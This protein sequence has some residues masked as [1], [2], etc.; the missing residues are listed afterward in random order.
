MQRKWLV[1]TLMALGLV[2]MVSFAAL[3]QLPAGIPREETFIGS[4]LTGR[5]GTPSN[6]N[7]WSGWRW[8]D[9]GIQQLLLEPLWTV[10]YATGEIISGL[11]A[12]LPIYNEDSTQ[13]TINLRQGVYWSDDVPLTAD[14][15]VFTI[16]LHARIPGLIYHGP[17]AEFMKKVYK[18]D[19]YTV[20]VELKKPNAHFHSYFVDRW[21]CLYI[22]PKHIFEKVGD[23]MTFE[24][25]PPVSCGPYILYDY[26]P[27]GFWTLWERRED[28]DRTPTGMLYGKPQP[29]YVL[30]RAF[31]SPETE[32]LAILRH[33]LDATHTTMEAMRAALS[34]GQTV[35][36]YY[37]EWPWAEVNHPCITGIM[38]NNM[39]APY[40]NKEVRW[41]L[42]L[43]INIVDYMSIA[44]DLIGAVSPIH[45]PVLSTYI[46]PFF[47]P[48]EEWLKE[49][50]LDLGN[51]EK[52]KPYDPEAPFKLAE[53]A[54]ERGYP[55]PT[56][57]ASIR[58]LFGIGWW[59]Y[60]PEVAEKLLEKNGFTRDKDGKWH[61]PN[62]TL[63]EIPIIT[64]PSPA[65]H[66]LKNANAVAEE[67]RRFGINASVV[68]TEAFDSLAVNG[69]FSVS[70]HWPI[71]EPWGVGVD[72]L[73]S[74]EPF[75]SH[76][77]APIGQPVANASGG[78]ARWF[79]TEL[80]HII[81]EM[82]ATNP[83]TEAE[84]LRL[85]GVEALKIT[86][87]EMPTIPTFTAC[88]GIVWDEYYW[89]NYPG[90][91]NR[92]CQPYQHFPN[93][94]YMLPFLQPQK[95]H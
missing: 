20:V 87:R 88:S 70:T 30:F 65:H 47:T 69:N 78:A 75:Y 29:K 19:N 50:E 95:N 27:A 22:M 76:F 89:T 86:A 57:V 37:K 85:S 73:R 21:G 34:R 83:F 33:E 28:W 49:F 42:V 81:E 53:A 3:A 71:C 56:D 52:F 11:A 72:L 35:K 64:N 2:L 66:H 51:G 24:F 82:Q 55:V 80:D 40:D 16:D 12:E 7:L 63:W 46:E 14:D 94:K 67:W 45:L 32:V 23:P 39:A 68:P 1:F 18:T 91:E 26:D 58:E 54:R 9:R 10:D 6:F 79:N 92:Y 93:F 38:F 17:I 41:A 36:T 43:A 13:M 90:A 62:G 61:L 60:A 25:N 74:F 5:V 48:M 15:V 8:Q 77:V 31:E 59:K 44:N 4:Q 84:K